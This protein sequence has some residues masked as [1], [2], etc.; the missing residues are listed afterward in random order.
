MQCTFMNI[1]NTIKVH[2][3]ANTVAMVHVPTPTKI[4]VVIINE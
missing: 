3:I 1:Q 4:P 2:F